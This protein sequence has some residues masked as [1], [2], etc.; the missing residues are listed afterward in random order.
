MRLDI[1][2]KRIRMQN[3]I[4]HLTKHVQVFDPVA[5]IRK[6]HKVK[7]SIQ[8]GSKRKYASCVQVKSTYVE[9]IE[10]EKFLRNMP[11]ALDD[12][13]VQQVGR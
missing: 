6:V 12:R 1:S 7:K 4:F 3:T 5:R 10:Q 2:P 11:K 8:T 13:I 9:T